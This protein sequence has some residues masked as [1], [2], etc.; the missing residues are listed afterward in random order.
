MVYWSK[1]DDVIFKEFVIKSILVFVMESGMFF[2]VDY[3]IEV[4]ER[5]KKW[6][7]YMK[8]LVVIEG[9]KFLLF[10]F[11][12]VWVVEFEILVLVL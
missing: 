5:I 7:K 1:D 11:E 12:N 8:K 2:D 3:D 10:I 4:F 9:D 6:E